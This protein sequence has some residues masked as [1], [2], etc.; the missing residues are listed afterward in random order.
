MITAATIESEFDREKGYE[1]KNGISIKKVDF[2]V[3]NTY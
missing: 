2:K 1:I 3:E